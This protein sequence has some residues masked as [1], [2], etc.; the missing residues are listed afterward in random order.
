MMKVSPQPW[1][2]II[3]R[4]VSQTDQNNIPAFVRTCEP[5]GLISYLLPNYIPSPVSSFSFTTYLSTKSCSKIYMASSIV[6]L[7]LFEQVHT[8]LNVK[9]SLFYHLGCS[10]Q[11]PCTILYGSLKGIISTHMHTYYVTILSAYRVC[12]FV[13][14]RYDHYWWVICNLEEY[15][16][17]YQWTYLHFP[18]IFWI[19]NDIPLTSQPPHHVHPRQR[20]CFIPGTGNN[21]VKVYLITIY[22]MYLTQEKFAEFQKVFFTGWRFPQI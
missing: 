22:Y 2:D 4:A 8:L 13:Q 20:P 21:L 3:H 16:S 15:N 19:P 7:S 1:W 5:L 6:F 11:C 12:W 18:D 17:Y 10:I 9:F 14:R